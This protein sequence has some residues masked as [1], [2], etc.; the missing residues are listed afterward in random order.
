[1][2]FFLLG[3][4]CKIEESLERRDGLKDLE[5]HARIILK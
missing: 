4:I 3:F 5:V 1:M 2:L